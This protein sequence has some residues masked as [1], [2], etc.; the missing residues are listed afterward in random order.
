MKRVIILVA[1]ISFVSASAREKQGSEIFGE[2]HK[3]QAGAKVMGACVGATNSQ[4]LWVNNVRTIIFTAGDMWWDLFGNGNAY[5]I[6][7]AIADKSKGISSLFAGSVWIGGLDA[8]GQLKVAAMTYRQTGYDY[9]PGPLDV[10]NA[11]TNSDVCNQYDKLF[12]MTRKEAEDA[13]FN[14]VYS[15]NIK[16]WPGNGDPTKNQG[17]LLAPFYDVDGNYAYNPLAGDYPYY[18]IYNAASKDNLG[19]CKAKLYGDVTLWWVFNDRGDIHTET[20]GQSIGLEIRGQA[21]GFKTNDDINNMTFYSYEIINRSSF[22]VNKTYLSVWTDADLGCYTDD[23]VGCDIKRGLGFIYNATGF[24]NTSCSGTNAYGDFPPALGCD[25]FRGPLADTL[26]LVDNDFDGLTDEPGETIG[27]AKFIYYNNNIGAFPPQ[28]TNPSLASHFYGY[29]TGFWKDGSAFTEGGNAY[30][31]STPVNYVY[32]GEVYPTPTGWNEFSAGNL[33][34]D[35]RFLQSAG[36]FTL[37][38]GAINNVTFGCPW[39]Q[40]PTKNGNLFSVA[41]LKTADDKAQALFDNC[42]KLLD[43]PEAPDMTIQEMNNQLLIYL[44]NLPKSNNYLNQYK[45]DDVTILAVDGQTAACLA[46]PNKTYNLEGYK[47]Y[48]VKDASVT[49]T[50]VEDATKAKLVFQCDIKNGI[51][52]LVNYNFDGTVGADVPKVKVEGSDLGLVSTFVVTE[53]AFATGTDKKLVNNRTYYFMAFAYAYNNYATY[54]PDTDPSAN[55]CVNYFGQKHPY[56]EGRKIKKAAGIPH[57]V[58]VE[59]DG[60]IYQAAYGYGPKITRFE[61]QGNGGNSLE[62]T[63]ASVD[64]ILSTGFAKNPTY[65][66]GRGPIQIKVVDPLNVPNSTFTVKL[67]RLPNSGTITVGTFTHVVLTDAK[68]TQYYMVGTNSVIC[69]TN[70]ALPA[71]WP[72]STL[73]SLNTLAYNYCRTSS[74]VRGDST[75]WLLKN[76]SNGDLYQP[77]KSIKIGE[78]YYFSKIGLSVNIQQVTDPGAS[79]GSSTVTG[80]FNKGDLI[81]ATMTFADP[82]KIWLTG[83][84]DNN[85]PVDDNW[86]R[87]GQQITEPVADF[88][89]NQGGNGPIDYD[90]VFSNVLNGTWAPYCLVSST[91]KDAASKTVVRAGP[92]YKGKFFAGSDQNDPAKVDPRYLSSVDVVITPDQS[93]WTRCLV[94]EMQDDSMLT[95][96]SALPPP[97]NRKARHFSPRRHQSVDKNGNYAAVG[98]GSSNVASDPNYI[99]ETGMG[100]FP[101]YAINVETGERLNMAFGEDSWNAADN[102]NDM[103]WNPTSRISSNTYDN[104]NGGRHYLYVFGNGHYDTYTITSVADINYSLNGTPFGAGRYDAGKQMS[105]Q[106][107]A[108]FSNTSTAVTAAANASWPLKNVLNDAM[109]VNIPLMKNGFSFKKQTDIP[110][111]VKIRLRV[112]KPYRYGYSSSW[113]NRVQL[114]TGTPS[115]YGNLTG[116]TYPLVTFSVNAT[117]TLQSQP[118]RLSRDT[119]ASA[120]NANMPMYQFSTADIYTMYGDNTTAKNVLDNIRVVPNPYYAF[121]SYESSRIDNRV[122]ITNLPS[123]CTVKI[124]TMNGTLIRTFKRDVSGQEDQITNSNEIVQSKRLPYQDWDLKNQ[125]GIPVASGLYIIYVDA[126]NP[127]GSVL[128]EKILKWFGVMR[129]LDLQSF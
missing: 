32:P 60:T 62:L 80:V 127:D 25:F 57:L 58:E 98:T 118:N 124:F 64:Q 94:I 9:W 46:K 55:P 43:G 56:L 16:N 3:T 123:L 83:L 48:Q 45:E 129:P 75:T 81:E 69:N 53:D 52:R 93:K 44:T 122:R 104:I 26:D 102:G 10:T 107:R 11:S 74:N 100:W 70:L 15:D 28:T 4:E 42:F 21:F 39:A 31:G 112:S 29:M 113:A 40:T 59:K 117:G 61:G 121:S 111:E 2:V 8:G 33:A 68:G 89:D 95:E 34:G 72:T 119:S 54:K 105:Q 14:G 115:S 17:N 51:S 41:L 120:Q 47:I 87:S 110:C 13:V 20:G 66:N 22:T 97:D 88:N 71:A 77:S 84:R 65:E 76:E 1:L 116:A 114:N 125:S 86:I 37:L 79:I 30:G 24:D 109:W 19:V 6:I 5:Y 96:T 91:T 101:G 92:G 12:T 73:A 106:W 18:D 7:P 78:E 36:P 103:L 90:K 126:R 35:R 85:G 108:T 99:A 82:H 50:D 49:Q 128:G 27:M 67:L 23:Y 63:Q 38:P